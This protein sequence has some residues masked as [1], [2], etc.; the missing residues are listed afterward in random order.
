[1]AKV[2]S[3]SEVWGGGAAIDTDFKVPGMEGAL[4][5]RPA[6]GLSGG[7]IYL[8]SNCN[9]GQVFKVVLADVAGHGDDVAQ[10]GQMLAELL[11]ANVSERDNHTFLSQ[12]NAQFEL[13]ARDGSVF[14]TLA[15]ATYFTRT[16][17]FCFAYA[18][19][20]QIILG[21]GGTF[22]PLALT[23]QPGI[24][25]VPIGIEST[26]DFHQGCLK[27]QV[28]DSLLLYTDGLIE[29]RN[30]TGQQYG[31]PRMLADLR[32][33]APQSPMSLK[34][35]LLTRLTDFVSPR[36]LDQDDITLIAVRLTDVPAPPV[37]KMAPEL[38]K[39][40]KDAKGK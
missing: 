31:L 21:R 24:T 22:E 16:Q 35:G 10:I 20:P 4:F 3:C 37:V 13:S 40:M 34:N 29:A 8:V 12:L 38:E 32:H 18:G 7:D 5:S 26:A 14:A 15:C 25:N 11:R 23:P 1:M 33:L 9:M 36:G 17:E 30:E 2:L 6:D 27:L 19:H 39:L 28:G